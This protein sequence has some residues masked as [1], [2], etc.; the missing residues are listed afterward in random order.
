[1]KQSIRLITLFLALIMTLTAL[2]TACQPVGTPNDGTDESA[3]EGQTNP[4]IPEDEYKLPP[5][6]GP[7]P[8][9]LLLDLQRQL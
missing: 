9:H 3:T 5:G 2:M 6:G 8:G 1:M 4:A 7:Q